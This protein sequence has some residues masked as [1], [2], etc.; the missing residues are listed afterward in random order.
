MQ[1]HPLTTRRATLIGATLLAAAAPSSAVAATDGTASPAVAATLSAGALTVTAP[2]ATFDFGTH[3]LTGADILPIDLAAWSVTD[4]TG[5]ALGWSLKAN[6]STLTDTVDSA[7]TLTG[8]VA[9]FK[10]LGDGTSAD[11]AATEGPDEEAGTGGYTDLSADD[12]ASSV[13]LASAA[14]GKGM[15]KWNFPLMSG[16]LRLRVPSNA[17]PGSYAGT[18]TLTLSQTP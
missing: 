10:A 12:A 6:V 7:K 18:L 4:A 14:T 15:G 17:V 16:G 9:Q 2:T 13:T 1:F 11:L 8:A 3:A 5:D